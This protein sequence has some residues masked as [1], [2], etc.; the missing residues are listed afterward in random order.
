MIKRVL[1]AV[2]SVAL[3]GFF[4]V[5]GAAPSGATV[6]PKCSG[7]GDFVK[8][9]HHYT[10]ADSGVDK[11]PRKD[12]VKWAGQITGVSGD[13]PYSGKIQ[14][15]LP[16]PFGKVS[17]DSWSGTTDSTGNSGTKHYDIPGFVPANVEFKVSGSHT[18]GSVTCT[19]SV[20][21]VIEGSVLGPFSLVTLA[22]TLA[23]GAGL[24]LAGL[25]GNYA[26]S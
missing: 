7:T 21:L 8:S 11:I 6:S 15:E 23:C 2:A 18:Q 1:L 4:V 9:G 24:I 25:Q 22:L 14:V 12:D 19:G 3:A 17:I 20:K 13:Q 26:G 16:P 10:A 5:A